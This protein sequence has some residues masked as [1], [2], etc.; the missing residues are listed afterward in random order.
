[1]DA[2]ED[3]S[4]AS[5]LPERDVTSLYYLATY[6]ADK[7]WKHN[8]LI[9]VFNNRTLVLLTVTMCKILN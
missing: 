6:P 8:R 3:S 9:Q 4:L 5:I 2:R 7:S 1:M